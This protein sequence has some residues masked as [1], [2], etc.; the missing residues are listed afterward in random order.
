MHDA[1]ECIRIQVGTSARRLGTPGL[2]SIISCDLI[3]L[4]TRC[5]SVH[6]NLQIILPQI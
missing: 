4:T 3:Q 1:R 5:R 2:R 6:P